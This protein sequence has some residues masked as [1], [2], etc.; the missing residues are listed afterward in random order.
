M[1]VYILSNYILYIYL[2]NLYVPIWSIFC[3]I[4]SVNEL[5]CIF[6]RHFCVYMYI[7][8]Y[9]IHIGIPF[10]ISK[11]RFSLNFLKKKKKQKRDAKNTKKKKRIRFQIEKNKQNFSLF[12]LFIKDTL[13][14][15]SFLSFFSL[16]FIYFEFRKTIIE[17]LFYIKS[18]CSH[19]MPIYIYL[20]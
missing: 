12:F 13:L 8:I 9:I 17:F 18:V 10:C 1:Q 5:L 14:Q 15:H 3:F 20:Y 7:C 11:C 4:Y 6:C 16:D 19:V 2:T